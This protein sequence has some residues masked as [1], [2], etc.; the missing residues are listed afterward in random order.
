MKE[1]RKMNLDLSV[2]ENAQQSMNAT[3][4][5]GIFILNIVLALAMLIRYIG[6][7]G[8]SLLYTYVMFTSS[9]DL[10]FCYVIVIFVLLVVYV[11]FKLLTIMGAYALVINVIKIIFKAVNGNLKGVELTNAEIII[12]C[13]ILTGTFVLMAINKISKINQ[14]N[15][16]KA[17]VQR[18]QSEELLQRTL[19]VAAIMEKVMAGADETLESCNTNLNS[20]ANVA[21]IMEN[22]K[23]EAAKL[24]AN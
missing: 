15:V 2:R 16:D 22:L 11:D 13:L 24:Q 5:S 4:M 6:G 17:D 9:T 23:D 20:I 21:G 7:I 3:A 8:F 1:K 18:T 19:D 12:A 10:A 14:A